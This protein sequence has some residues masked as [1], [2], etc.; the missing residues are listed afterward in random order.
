MKTVI[1]SIVKY[2]LT[3]LGGLL[4]TSGIIDNEVANQFVDS[5]TQVITGCLMVLTAYIPSLFKKKKQ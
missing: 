5:T 3:L 2:G 4:V 1:A